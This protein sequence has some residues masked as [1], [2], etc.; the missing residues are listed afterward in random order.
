MATDLTADPPAGTSAAEDEHGALFCYRHPTRETYIRC[1][2]C[3]RPICTGCAMLGPV[4]SRCKTCGKLANDPLTSFTPL[5]LIGGGG[6]AVGA[7]FVGGLVGVT[8]YGF[9]S[10]IVGFFVGGFT[11]ELVMR[12]VGWKRGPVMIAILMGGIALGAAVA[13]GYTLL[14]LVGI[15]DESGLG[16]PWFLQQY[17][18]GTII[19]AAAAMAGAWTRI[20]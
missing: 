13:L 19:Y 16:F 2:R 5:Q 12:V 17:A 8:G 7:G 20:R 10:I 6:V 18:M 4:G 11:A 15:V 3:E 9:L 1:G 14:P